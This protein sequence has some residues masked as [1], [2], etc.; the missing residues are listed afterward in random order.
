MADQYVERVENLIRVVS[1][2][3]DEDFN[4][5]RAPEHRIEKRGARGQARIY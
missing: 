1:A 5:G 4:L 3:R 2:V